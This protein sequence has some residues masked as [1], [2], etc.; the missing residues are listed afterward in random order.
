MIPQ[1][2]PGLRITAPGISE[3]REGSGGGGGRRL[4]LRARL[5]GRGRTRR[6]EQPKTRD[7]QPIGLAGQRRGQNSVTLGIARELLRERD[8]FLPLDRFTPTF[9]LSHGYLT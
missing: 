8:E 2:T 4:R 7:H 1:P 5:G 6:F 9:R 3:E